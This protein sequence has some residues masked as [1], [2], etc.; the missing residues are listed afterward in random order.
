MSLFFI[1]F[2]KD[3][4]VKIEMQISQNLGLCT[5]RGGSIAQS[6]SCSLIEA[7]HC[8]LSISS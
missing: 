4:H 1:F 3:G 6:L 5:S 2:L 7:L 8:F